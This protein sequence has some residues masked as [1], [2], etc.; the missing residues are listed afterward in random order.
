MT[1]VEEWNEPGDVG[2]ILAFSG[3]HQ[4]AFLELNRTEGQKEFDGLSLQ[5]RV[6]R[7]TDFLAT[8][9][10]EIEFE[11]PTE[12]PW[13]SKYLHLRDP[14]NIQVIIYEGGF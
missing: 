5:F 9:C 11:G 2:A 1:V 6:D 13:G 10:D 8:L 12:R 3:G 7:V 4:E 14:D